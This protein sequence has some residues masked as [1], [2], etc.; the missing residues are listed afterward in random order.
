[1]KFSLAWLGTHLET[2]APVERDRRDPLGIGLEVES[3]T[4][5]G[6]ALA[7]FR[8][9]QVVEAAPHPNADRLKACRVETGDGS[10]SPSSAARPTPTP[11]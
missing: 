11:A 9:A 6:A 2:A 7:P 1:M 8:I 5:R 3:V 10:W 4:D